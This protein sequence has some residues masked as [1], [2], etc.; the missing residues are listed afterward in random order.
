MLPAAPRIHIPTFALCETS[1]ARVAIAM[2]LT[3]ANV[4]KMWVRN[5]SSSDNAVIVL[6]SIP[7]ERGSGLVEPTALHV[8]ATAVLRG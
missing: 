2:P 8:A 6:T 3:V 7:T 5:G 4:R 1:T